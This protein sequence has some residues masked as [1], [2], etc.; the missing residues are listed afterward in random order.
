[1]RMGTLGAYYRK[2]F[3]SGDSF[4]IDGFVGRSLFDL[5]SNFTF[6]LNDSVRGD[7]FQQHDSRF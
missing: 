1:V 5:Y 4:K 7:A 2:G 3:A 6:F